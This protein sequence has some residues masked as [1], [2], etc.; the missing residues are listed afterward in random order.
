LP[1]LVHLATRNKVKM[2]PSFRWDDDD[3]G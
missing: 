1:L 2:D 3:N